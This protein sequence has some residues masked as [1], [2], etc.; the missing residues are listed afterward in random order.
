MNN[1][2]FTKLTT[3]DA[4]YEQAFNAFIY[5]GRSGKPEMTLIKNSINIIITL[6]IALAKAS[7][8]HNSYLG[9]HSQEVGDLAGKIAQDL[10]FNEFDTV[11]IIL[12]GYVHDI[13]KLS[14]PLS[15]IL[16]PDRLQPAEY[17]LVKTHTLYGSELLKS[18]NDKLALWNLADYPLMHHERNDGSGY[19]QKL[20]KDQIPIGVQIVAICDVYHAATSH[21]P[22]NIKSDEDFANLFDDKKFDQQIVN[23]LKKFI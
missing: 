19:P 14:I 4:F 22:Y 18:P 20:I 23:S 13:G 21:R 11:G 12:G 17:E 1:E 5:D 9:N 16:K 6:C 8:K 15:I 10:G 3:S 2:I 7:N